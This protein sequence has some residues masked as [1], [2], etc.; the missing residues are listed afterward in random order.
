MYKSSNNLNVVTKQFSNIEEF[1]EFLNYPFRRVVEILK[2]NPLNVYAGDNVATT[3]GIE[4]TMIIDNN[5]L[6]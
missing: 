6:D 1:E 3:L 2:Y 4:V 5:L